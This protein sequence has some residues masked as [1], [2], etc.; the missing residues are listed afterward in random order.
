MNERQEINIT[1]LLE[2]NIYSNVKQL[3]ELFSILKS[4]N[5]KTIT[6]D[7][8]SNISNSVYLKI[9]KYLKYAN[10]NLELKNN[11]TDI[12]K[13]SDIL[14]YF[15]TVRLEIDSNNEEI[16][17]KMNNNKE[18]YKIGI[19]NYNYLKSCFKDISIEIDTYF[20]KHNFRNLGDM[21]NLIKELEIDNWNI[22]YTN[23]IKIEEEYKL[24]KEMIDK[25]IEFYDSTDLTDKLN[26]IT[27]DE[28]KMMIKRNKKIPYTLL[29][30]Y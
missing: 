11:G 14:H 26:S 8:D 18:Q 17:E 22:L 27:K 15:N 13:R 30:I 2:N 7:D 5:I 6:I 12:S 29:T 1:Y 16:L 23:D 10:F 19:N 24:S 4:K 9:L 25:I 3:V 20:T 21:Y 28:S